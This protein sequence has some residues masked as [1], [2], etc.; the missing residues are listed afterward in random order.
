MKRPAAADPASRK[1]AGGAKRPAAAPRCAS[2]KTKATAAAKPSKRKPANQK[3]PTDAPQTPEMLP[4][5][6]ATA[7]NLRTP[8]PKRRSDSPPALGP[9]PSRQA[10]VLA[11]L[12]L[13][14]AWDGLSDREKLDAL[15]EAAMQLTPIWLR[16]QR[17]H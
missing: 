1:G 14:D 11:P 9:M 17:D 15:E 12:F 5:A 13:L 2:G 7:D 8:S 6:Q 3:Q 10:Q 4:E 16:E